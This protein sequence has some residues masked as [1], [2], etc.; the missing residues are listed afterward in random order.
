MPLIDL[1]HLILWE[2]VE[3]RRIWLARCVFRVPSFQTSKVVNQHT[4]LEHT[5]KAQPLPKGKKRWDSFHILALPGD[6][7]VCA[8]FRGVL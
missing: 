1:K 8:F 5:P 2:A 7:R 4:E 6:C 3:E